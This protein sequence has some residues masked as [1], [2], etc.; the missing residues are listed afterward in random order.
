MKERTENMLAAGGFLALLG[1]AIAVAVAAPKETG[2]FLDAVGRASNRSD[3]LRRIHDAD[4]RVGTCEHKLRSAEWRLDV[5]RGRWSPDYVVMSRL[6][7]DIRMA[8]S[9]LSMAKRDRRHC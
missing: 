2:E 8:E 3:Q 5:E 7:R 9:E 1:G 4:R 6:R